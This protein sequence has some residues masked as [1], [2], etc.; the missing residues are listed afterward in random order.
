M[1]H[2]GVFTRSDKCKVFISNFLDFQQAHFCP[3]IIFS[4]FL[5]LADYPG[6]TGST[7]MIIVCLPDSSVGCDID[8]REVVLSKI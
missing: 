8:P 1:V 5:W 3:N 2:H 4:Q 7:N 6:P